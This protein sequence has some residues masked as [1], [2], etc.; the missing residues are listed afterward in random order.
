[1]QTKDQS[2]EA[3]TAEL[4]AAEQERYCAYMLDPM[5]NTFRKWDQRARELKEQLR[6]IEEE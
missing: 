2:R 1:M 6:F 4:K 5:G 3:I